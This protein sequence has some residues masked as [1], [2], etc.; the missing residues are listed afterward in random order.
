MTYV[1]CPSWN[2]ISGF[3]E[4][5]WIKPEQEWFTNYVW[6]IRLFQQFWSGQR[7]GRVDGKVR[8]INKAFFWHLG[9]E[10]IFNYSISWASLL[11]HHNHNTLKH[12]VWN[13][14]LEINWRL[15]WKPWSFS[16]QF[17]VLWPSYN[18]SWVKIFPFYNKNQSW[19]YFKKSRT[20]KLEDK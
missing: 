13:N 2:F 11:I 6:L 16:F 12:P 17:I 14:H 7:E 19:I 10:W 20:N 4:N 9:H 8:P 5:I 18:Q 3:H 15:E 1:L